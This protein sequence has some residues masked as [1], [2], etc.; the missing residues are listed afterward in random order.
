MQ[1]NAA[2]FGACTND[3]YSEEVIN[4]SGKENGGS[5][6]ARSQSTQG[7]NSGAER[8]GAPAGPGLLFVEPGAAHQESERRDLEISFHLCPSMDQWHP[9]QFR[10]GD[11]RWLLRGPC[12]K[13]W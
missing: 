6:R 1:V 9:D 3:F 5:G 12:A 10:V 13:P 8:A 2:H 7:A 4:G 11:S